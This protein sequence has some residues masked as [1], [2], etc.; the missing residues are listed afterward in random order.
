MKKGFT[1]IEILIVVAVI[2]VLGVIVVSAVL[3]MDV[4]GKPTARTWAADMGYEIAALTCVSRDSDA[5]GYVS[6]MVKTSEGEVFNLE[7][8]YWGHGQ[9]C[10]APQPKIRVRGTRVLSETW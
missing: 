6:C 9:S 3:T 7:C 8:Q 10:K 4:D 5:D 1:L 2:A